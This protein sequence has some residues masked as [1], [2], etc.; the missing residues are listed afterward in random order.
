M[1]L[2]LD[3]TLAGENRVN[4]IIKKFGSRVEFLYRQGHFLNLETQNMLGI[5]LVQPNLDYSISCWFSSI[6]QGL[7]Q[8]LQIAHNKLV[9]FILNKNHRYHV[10]PDE[11]KKVGCWM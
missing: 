5:A 4:N 8:K 10:G 3:Q 7:K 1:D 2:N 6:S 11:L 9:H